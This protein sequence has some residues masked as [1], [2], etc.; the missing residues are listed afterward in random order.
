VSQHCI[1]AQKLGIINYPS[2]IE[3][4]LHVQ[5]FPAWPFADTLSIPSLLVSTFGGICQRHET[6]LYLHLFCYST[7]AMHY[8]AMADKKLDRP[9]NV[10]FGYCYGVERNLGL[11]GRLTWR[12]F[13]DLFVIYRRNHQCRLY[14]I[15]WQED[16]KMNWPNHMTAKCQ[17]YG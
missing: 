13:Y 4:A 12:Y 17:M 2:T 5:E 10:D 6:L 1:R 7:R 9:E 16:Q 3:F 14:R 15:E 8:R 11:E